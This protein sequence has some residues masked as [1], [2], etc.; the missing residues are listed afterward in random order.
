M[1][2]SEANLS[3]PGWVRTLKSSDGPEVSGRAGD[4]SGCLRR[5]IIRAR[6][7]QL[8]LAG[9]ASIALPA[10]VHAQT[11]I[12]LTNL[13]PSGMAGGATADT[14]LD[15]S[16]GATALSTGNLQPGAVSS[17]SQQGSNSLNV[18]GTATTPLAIGAAG[19][20][21]VSV[22]TIVAA[23]LD[24]TSGAPSRTSLSV[25]NVNAAVA[26]GIHPIIG[27][28]PQLGYGAQAAGTSVGGAQAGVNTLNAVSIGLSGAAELALS[29]L[30]A[31]T[32]GS[33]A[34]VQPT[35]GSLTTPP[36]SP[37]SLAAV[38]PSQAATPIPP[39][40]NMSVVNVLVGY[41]AAG[42]ARVGSAGG[43][44]TAQSASNAFNGATVVGGQ[45]VA[46]QQLADFPTAQP[47]SNGGA[48]NVLPTTVTFQTVNTA[49]AYAGQ[50]ESA[51]V[52][53]GA[54]LPS[55]VASVSNVGQS[56]LNS[57]NALALTPAPGSASGAT[58]GLSGLQSGSL[59]WVMASNQAV[60]SGA[61]GP[62]A[63]GILLSGNGSANWD[64]FVASHVSAGLP[65]PG[66]VSSAAAA[67]PASS[68]SV[69]GVTQGIGIALNTVSSGGGV[70][71]G[72][73]GFGQ[74]IGSLPLVNSVA[75]GAGQ[76]W[77]LPPSSSSFTSFAPM[78]VN[79]TVAVGAAGGA[80]VEAATQTYQVTGN[81]ISIGGN[82][83]GALSQS[84][85]SVDYNAAGLVPA[86]SQGAYFTGAAPVSGSGAAMGAAA[87]PSYGPY[88]ASPIAI[89]D[90][91]ALNGAYAV[92]LGPGQSTL[93]GVAQAASGDVNSISVAGSLSSG[94]AGTVAQ[95]G[96]TLAN[97]GGTL[98]KQIALTNGA[99]G[100]SVWAPQQTLTMQVNSVRAGG[101]VSGSITQQGPESP[102][103]NAIFQPSNAIEVASGTAGPAS[104]LGASGSLATQTNLR[105]YNSVA[106]A[107][108]LGTSTEVAAVSQSAPAVSYVVDGV[109]PAPSNG[110]QVSAW[111]PVT[112]PGQATDTRS[113]STQVT[114]ASQVAGL[115]VNGIAAA[116]GAIGKVSQVSGGVVS[117]TSN[118]QGALSGHCSTCIVQDAVPRVSVGNGYTVI[119]GASQSNAQAVNTASYGGYLSGTINAVAAGTTT[120]TTSNAV[121]GTANLGSA[122]L[123]GA[124]AAANAVSAITATR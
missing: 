14:N 21:S 116:T 46:L 110:I 17:L 98:N 64:G 76:A 86:Q 102:T 95:S 12:N 68:A 39:T 53:G 82:A 84:V 93:S 51:N 3:P 4:R 48:W 117:N 114:G 109:T 35:V 78:P 96:G 8:L 94:A 122:R 85:G 75:N 87:T 113:A 123:S 20:P 10:S 66:S 1:S 100:A 26:N 22:N 99:G 24:A 11:V 54:R 61:V 28:V 91:P 83:T 30:S 56:S 50:L 5:T 89:G 79:A 45:S 81:A 69:A 119:A 55:T 120:L 111:V 47:A 18:I 33:G 121:N 88:V 63:N 52:S 16:N 34:L 92:L 67:P 29:Q 9:T 90:G 80:R 104:V 40:L 97:Y 60:A 103:A 57:I 36:G 112:P 70:Q 107:S 58:T 71:V 19:N 59:P 77:A 72:P 2:S 38:D 74:S 101:T 118:V 27:G 106:T 13:P 15:V 37:Y 43:N 42:P 31:A 44:S 25:G 41:S 108:T 124:Q 6:L 49:T 105:T 32:D 65:A 62:D 23:G 73:S 115:S 7:C